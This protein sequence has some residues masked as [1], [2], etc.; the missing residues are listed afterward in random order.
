MESKRDDKKKDGKKSDIS[1]HFPVVAHL[2][3][4]VILPRYR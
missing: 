3:L 1:G 4:Q 2:V